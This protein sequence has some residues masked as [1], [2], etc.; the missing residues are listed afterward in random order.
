[1][2]TP[3]TQ[4]SLANVELEIYG[5]TTAAISMNDLNVRQLAGATN[6]AAVTMTSLQS[7]TWAATFVPA[8]NGTYS[9]SGI[10]YSSYI[11][12]SSYYCVWSYTMSNSVNGNASVANNGTSNTITFDV[13]T[14]IIDT[15]TNTVVVT[16]TAGKLIRSY[17][18]NLTANPDS[19]GGVMTL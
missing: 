8:A 6:T 1:M 17:T 16:G 11:L 3:A 5:T 9:N 19:G 13:R 10:S 12:T 14:G 18:L 4:I 7:K 2:T 15:H